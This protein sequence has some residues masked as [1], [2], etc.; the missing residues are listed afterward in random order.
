[1]HIVLVHIAVKPEFL[2][3]F[4]RATRDNAGNSVREEGILR[5]DVLQQKDDPCR[6]VLVEVYRRVEDQAA[7]RETAHYLRWRDTV[8]GMMA[9]PRVGVSYGNFYPADTGW[10]RV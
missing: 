2:E 7:H 10:A 6:F 5:F 1:M 4:K 8:A 3:E 9:E